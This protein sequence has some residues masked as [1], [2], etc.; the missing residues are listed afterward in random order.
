MSL[1][2]M[3][4]IRCLAGTNPTKGSAYRVSIQAGTALP[5]PMKRRRPGF[6]P[7]GEELAGAKS[8]LLAG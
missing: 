2:S 4:L 6:P 8:R 5:A 3:L 7:K 1:I